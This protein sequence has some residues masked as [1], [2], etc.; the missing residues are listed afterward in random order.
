MDIS[1]DLIITHHPLIF[2]PLRNINFAIP[3]GRLLRSLIN[4]KISLYS[5]HTNL[6]RCEFGTGMVLADKLGLSSIERYADNPDDEMNMI[7]TGRFDP[8][9]SN[10]EVVNLIKDKL[11]CKEFRIIGEIMKTVTVAVV[12]GSGGSLIRKVRRPFDLIITG[13]ISY[14]DALEAASHSQAVAVLGHYV[15]EKPMMHYLGDI[16]RKNFPDL[17]IQ[18]ASREGEPYKII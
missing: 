15:S 10:S 13:E 17:S 1:A 6:D 14:H 9:L 12:P 2:K 18:V 4:H 8:E 16:L 7:I 11:N 5:A 3:V